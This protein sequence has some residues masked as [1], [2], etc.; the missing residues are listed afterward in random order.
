MALLA[1]FPNP[2]NPET[3]IPYRRSE[4]T[5][6]RI[7]IH[8]VSGLQVRLL[9]IGTKPAG[10]YISRSQA[11]CWDGRNDAGEAVSSGLYFTR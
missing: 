9:Y 4:L 10:D 11:A 1:N 8:D 6:V 3:W 5:D 7:Q 2:L